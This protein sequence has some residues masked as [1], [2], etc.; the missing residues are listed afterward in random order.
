MFTV[1]LGGLCPSPA[2]R[3]LRLS[4]YETFRRLCYDKA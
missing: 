2:T 4:F 3:F 1:S